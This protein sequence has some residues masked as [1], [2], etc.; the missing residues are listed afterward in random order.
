MPVLPI[1]FFLYLL[2]LDSAQLPVCEWKAG[3]SFRIPDFFLEPFGQIEHVGCGK[4]CFL[5][6]FY[7]RSSRLISIICILRLGK[8][9]VAEYCKE[10]AQFLELVPN[11]IG[12]QHAICNM[13]DSASQAAIMI[14]IFLITA[15]SIAIL[16][17]Q[18]SAEQIHMSHSVLAD[19]RTSFT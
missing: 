17:A 12:H 18:Y 4:E 8:W 5:Y 6:H 14:A 13:K 11:S 1:A 9:L 10:L 7:F 3:I 19:I 16:S 15:I 2:I